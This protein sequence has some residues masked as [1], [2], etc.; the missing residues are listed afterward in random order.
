MELRLEIAAV[1][2]GRRP[3]ALDHGGL[4]PAGTRARARLCGGKRVWGFS[5]QGVSL[6]QS[7]RSDAVMVCALHGSVTS[8]IT[9]MPMTAAAAAL[10]LTLRHTILRLA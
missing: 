9:S 2:A 7:G 3:G 8:D 10:W 5:R 4:E 1:F 6:C